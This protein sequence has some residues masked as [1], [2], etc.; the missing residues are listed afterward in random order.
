[1]NKFCTAS[2]F[3]LIVAILAIVNQYSI[4]QKLSVKHSG[5]KTQFTHK[6]LNIFQFHLKAAQLVISIRLGVV[7]ALVRKE[8]GLT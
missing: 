7:V 2:F 5:M 4:N 1:M 6:N 8:A 3:Q